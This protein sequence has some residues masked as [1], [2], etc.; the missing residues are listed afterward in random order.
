M[1]RLPQALAKCCR[2]ASVAYLNRF[3]FLDPEGWSQKATVVVLLL[4]I[5]SLRVQKSL[6]ATTLCI[7]IHDD[8]AQTVAL[9]HI[10]VGDESLTEKLGVKKNDENWG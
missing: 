3:V 5:S 10:S 8:I 6:S 7:H 2:R 4:G 9:R 1:K